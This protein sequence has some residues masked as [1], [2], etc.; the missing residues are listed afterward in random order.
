MEA[1]NQPDDP[2]IVALKAIEPDYPVTQV[3]R[4][5]S[6]A[7]AAAL[8]HVPARLLRAWIHGHYQFRTFSGPPNHDDFY[9]LAFPCTSLAH[10]FA[11]GSAGVYRLKK[12]LEKEPLPFPPLRGPPPFA[13]LKRRGLIATP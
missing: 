6:I 11:I 2:F 13:K 4:A 8:V 10:T 7:R 1:H 12:L 9:I 3:G 5:Y